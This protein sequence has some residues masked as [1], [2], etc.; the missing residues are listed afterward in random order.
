VIHQAES[1]VLEDSHFRNSVLHDTEFYNLPK[2]LKHTQASNIF[3]LSSDHE[4]L[5]LVSL[6]YYN[7]KY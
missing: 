3:G 6:K 1:T 5:T 7:Y 4:L 2:L